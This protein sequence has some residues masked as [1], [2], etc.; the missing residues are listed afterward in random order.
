MSTVDAYLA[1]SV[2]VIMGA[3][4]DL[5]IMLTEG[6][7]E[8]LH[9][10]SFNMPCVCC[11]IV[12][13]KVVIPWAPNRIQLTFRGALKEGSNILDSVY[14]PAVNLHLVAGK[15]LGKINHEILQK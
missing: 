13:G 3:L 4:K 15:G 10:A 9:I 6:S 5:D 12:E 2:G 7:F 11:K 1:E 8:V 14:F